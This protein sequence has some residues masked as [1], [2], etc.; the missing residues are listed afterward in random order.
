MIAFFIILFVILIDVKHYVI[1][2]YTYSS[3]I[4]SLNLHKARERV[5]NNEEQ[6][7]AGI[8]KVEKLRK[9]GS[10]RGGGEKMM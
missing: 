6:K 10:V 3:L 8:I 5:K 2:I 9:S 1:Q 7:N 4:L